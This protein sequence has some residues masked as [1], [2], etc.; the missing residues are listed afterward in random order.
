[1]QITRSIPVLKEL[2]E[3]EWLLLS[4][5]LTY[6]IELHIAQL[7]PEKQPMAWQQLPFLVQFWPLFLKY[8]KDITLFNRVNPSIRNGW[9]TE[10][11]KHSIYKNLPKEYT[12][13]YVDILQ[14]D[15]PGKEQMNTHHKENNIQFPCMIKANVGERGVWIYYISTPEKRD[16]LMKRYNEELILRQPSTLQSFC[17]WP[18]EWC[19]QFY[20][21][22]ERGIQIWSLVKRNIPYVLGNEIHTVEELMKEL[23][24]SPAQHQYIYSTLQAEE[25]ET[26]TYIPEKDERIQVVRKASIDFWTT[27][28]DSTTT[29]TE[30]QYKKLHTLL[31]KLLTKLPLLSIWRFDLK[32]KHLDWLLAWEIRLIECNAGWWI[33]TNVYDESLSIQEKYTILETHFELMKEIALINKTSEAFQQNN[34]GSVRELIR[35]SIT[36]LRKKWITFTDLGS[37]NRTHVIQ[38]YKKIIGLMR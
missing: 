22:P 25:P 31:E 20:H 18:E 24:I 1:M 38:T 6:A 7:S 5:K 8:R 27:Y 17:D 11:D 36:S 23:P 32:A 9:L 33:P 37:K 3:K 13:T 10:Y 29:L 15:F 30:T 26:I 21:H 4:E 34:I 28:S 2:L 12:I 14:P 35:S 19:L 16:E